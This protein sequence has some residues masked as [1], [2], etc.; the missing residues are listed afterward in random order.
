MCQA[1][2][3]NNLTLYIKYKIFAEYEIKPAKYVVSFV[4]MFISLIFVTFKL[5]ENAFSKKL[6]ILFTFTCFIVIRS[7]GYLTP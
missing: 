4:S 6:L 7:V 1:P 3:Y 5:T 2:D